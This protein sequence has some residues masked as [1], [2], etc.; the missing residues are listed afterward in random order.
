M[1]LSA[2]D[3][4][5]IKAFVASGM[6]IATLPEWAYSAKRDA[7]LKSIPAR[8]L[9]A[10]ALSYLWLQR[11]PCLRGYALQFIEM[12]S[13]VWSPARVRQA[14]DDEQELDDA[15]AVDLSVRP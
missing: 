11:H 14:L 1:V 2:T 7:G 8:H 13:Q 10:P 12:L 4:D 5:V 15:L 9:F 6:G 3:A